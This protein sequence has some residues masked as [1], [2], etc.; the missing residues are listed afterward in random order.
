[1]NDTNQN[2]KNHQTQS[3]TESGGALP[4]L[5]LYT[6]PQVNYHFND[7]INAFVLYEVTAG[8]NTKAEWDFN[9]YR[10]SNADVEPGVD[11]KLHKRITLTPYLHWFTNQSIDTT[12]MNVAAMIN[13]L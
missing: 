13:L 3:Q 2:N 9:N 1:M 11:F 12:T 5:E 4:K 8:L 7:S 10:S 6:G